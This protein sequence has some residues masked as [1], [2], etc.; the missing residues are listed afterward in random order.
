MV[1]FV[2]LLLQQQ[3]PPLKYVSLSVSPNDI[4]NI[5]ED[6]LVNEA[7]WVTVTRE[8]LQKSGRR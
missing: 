2:L 1:Y 7:Y 4:Q 5:T 6:V 8:V 3:Q